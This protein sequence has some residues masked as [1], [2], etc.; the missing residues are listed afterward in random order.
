MLI[1]PGLIFTGLYFTGRVEVISVDEPN[2][3]LFVNLTMKYETHT[4]NW[5]EEW[6]LQHVLWG[7]DKGEYF[8]KDFPDYPPTINNI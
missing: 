1:Q 3:I 7:F 2:N 5:S 6:N 4:S 8:I